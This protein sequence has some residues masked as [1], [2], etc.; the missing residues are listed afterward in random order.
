MKGQYLNVQNLLSLSEHR[1][2]FCISSLK[3]SLNFHSSRT[4]AGKTLHG[5]IG[6]G[7]GQLCTSSSTNSHS[8]LAQRGL[9]TLQDRTEGTE[10]APVCPRSLRTLF[11]LSGPIAQQGKFLPGA[12][13]SRCRTRTFPVDREENSQS[14]QAENTLSVLTT[15]TGQVTSQNFLYQTADMESKAGKQTQL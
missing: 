13:V 9:N 6:A 8:L 14:V 5:S 10:S 12:D 4:A 1:E 15:C 7:S 3:I 11:L 2:R